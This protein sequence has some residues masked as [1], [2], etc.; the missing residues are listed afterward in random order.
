VAELIKFFDFTPRVAWFGLLVLSAISAGA[1]AAI[2]AIVN[3]RIASLS[4]DSRL[5]QEGSLAVVLIAIACFALAHRALVNGTTN[6]VENA[7]RNARVRLLERIQ[8]VELHDMEQLDVEQIYVCI[9]TE[10]H[11]IADAAFTFATLGE[12][13]LVLVFTLI[14]LSWLSGIGFFCAL[15][16]MSISALMHFLRSAEVK[17]KHQQ[18]FELGSELN[19]RFSDSLAGFKESKLNALRRIEL[20]KVATELADALLE[21]KTRL[22]KIVASSHISSE[23][24]Y[25][26]FVVAIVFLVPI[27]GGTSGNAIAMTAVSALFLIGPTSAVVSAIPLLQKTGAAARNIRSVEIRLGEFV[28]A[29]ATDHSPNPEFQS[30]SLKNVSYRYGGSDDGFSFGPIDLNLRRGEIT[31]ITGGNGSGKSTLLKLL[32]GLYVPENGELRLDNKLVN[33]ANLESYRSLFTAIFA[34]NHIFR[35]LYGISPPEPSE[36]EELFRLMELEHKSGI[37]GRTFRD[38]KLSTGQRKRLAMI[39]LVL[40][41]RPICIFDE[42]AADQDIHFRQKFYQ[43]LLPWLKSIGKTVIAVTHDERYFD[44]A[45]Q[46]IHLEA[47]SRIR[48]E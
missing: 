46:R 47:P 31:F 41:R 10:M 2:L 25:F 24:S 11:V 17:N 22:N 35:T 48:T 45:D 12:Q 34:D 32:C 43:V 28:K 21:A 26:A 3:A 30:I 19:A 13:T 9:N 1:S 20:F 5:Q 16:F 29:P 15:A 44:A 23:I 39:A 7:V 37:V 14:Y 38:V 33:S 4:A 42:W 27:F 6:L 36:V 8:M 40:E 18:A